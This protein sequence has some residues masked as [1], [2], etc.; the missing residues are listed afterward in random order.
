[1]A[2]FLDA[3]FLEEYPLQTVAEHEVLIAF[4]KDADAASLREWWEDAG[5]LAFGE[6]LKNNEP[7]F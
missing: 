7:G 4:S 2:R 3:D 5:A 1:M 6:W